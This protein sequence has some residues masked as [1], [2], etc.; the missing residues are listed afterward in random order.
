MITVP[1]GTLSRNQANTEVAQRRKKTIRNL[2]SNF[3]SS[4]LLILSGLIVIYGH[5][6]SI[7]SKEVLS[8]ADAVIAISA[9]ALL[10]LTIYPMMKESG[11]IL[12]Q[13]IPKH[14]D[15]D[16]LKMSLLQYFPEIRSI[17]DLHIWCLT[18]STVIATCHVSL[19]SNY[20]EESY[21]RLSKSMNDFFAREGITSVTIQPEFSYDTDLEHVPPTPGQSPTTL[22]KKCLYTCSSSEDGSDCTEF[23]CCKEE[24]E[25]QALIRGVQKINQS[26]RYT[27]SRLSTSD[28]H[29]E[30]NC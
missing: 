5:E 1:A 19:P 4:L 27:L 11:L 6:Q 30:C 3:S 20:T 22:S 13:T 16:I 15:V 10:S 25:T 12:L 21:S 24:E 8:V 28:D 14:I 17:H 29:D 9:V 26:Q 18:S 2:I 23:K 7:V